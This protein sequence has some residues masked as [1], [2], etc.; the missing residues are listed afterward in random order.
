[1]QA[2][3]FTISASPASLTTPVGSHTNSTITLASINSFTG[4]IAL[5]ASS[6][7]TGPTLTL[8]PTSITLSAQGTG[9]S[10]LT[11]S[12]T[13]TGNFTVTVIGSSGSLSHNTTITF[14]VVLPDFVIS[15]NPGSL[16]IGQV[17]SQAGTPVAVNSTGDRTFFESSY[18]A[19]SFNAKG[20]IWLFYEDSRFTCEHQTGCL[21][22]TTSTNGSR[23]ALPARVPVHITDSDFSVYT[24]GASVFYARYNETSFESTCGK[25]I[26]FGLG[27]LNTSGTITWQPEQT[28][29]VCA[30]NR[31]Y[32]ND[33]TTVDSNG[34]VWIA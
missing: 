30:S 12:S 32:P 5:T 17:S 1:N 18:L 15:A 14:N 31:D 10:T 19:Q 24:D 3:D 23:W 29:A 34:Q 11:F 20:L 13:L 8:N 2:S 16:A 26:Q 25:K 21:T 22:Y 28:V 4:T 33:E 7:P 6:S 27:A 9:T